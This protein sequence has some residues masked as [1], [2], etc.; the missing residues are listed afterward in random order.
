LEFL[1]KLPAPPEKWQEHF[2]HFQSYS[3][4]KAMKFLKVP[5]FVS[6]KVF[7][8]ISNMQLELGNN[9]LDWNLRSNQHHQ[10]SVASILIIENL[11]WC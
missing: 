8:V 9:T 2:E 1:L 7:A 11:I 4:S 3:H 5:E 6:T 10:S